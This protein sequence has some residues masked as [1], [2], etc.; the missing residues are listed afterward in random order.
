MSELVKLKLTFP[1]LSLFRNGSHASVAKRRGYATMFGH[2]PAIA[3]R[4]EVG[5]SMRALSDLLGSFNSNK[6]DA[7]YIR[8]YEEEL[9]SHVRDSGFIVNRGPEESLAGYVE[10]VGRL[11]DSAV[12]SKIE[13]RPHIY[14]EVLDDRDLV[15]SI[16]NS[17]SYSHPDDCMI[18]N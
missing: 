5:E 17:I 6:G 12:D 16:F 18:W 1:A 15:D 7:T 11:L 14:G 2:S 10:R 9:A 4:Y 8:E 13:T 3:E